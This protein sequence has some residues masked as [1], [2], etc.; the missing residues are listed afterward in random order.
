MCLPFPV[1]YRNGA[2]ASLAIWLHD[3]DFLLVLGIIII[4]I[5]V[6]ALVRTQKERTA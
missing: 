2:K 1:I 4:I 3:I 5:I 6:R